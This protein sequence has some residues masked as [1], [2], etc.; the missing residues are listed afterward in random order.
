[1]WPADCR[2]WHGLPA[3]TTFSCVYNDKRL[4]W[5]LNI[6]SCDLCRV[7]QRLKYMYVSTRNRKDN[8]KTC[9][10]KSYENDDYF[11]S[12]NFNFLELFVVFCFKCCKMEFWRHE[13]I[14][15]LSIGTWLTD[16]LHLHIYRRKMEELQNAVTY[17][18]TRIVLVLVIKVSK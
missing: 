10:L 12:R 1:M 4:E 8:A 9:H 2:G 14:F 15:L 18:L 13:P 7:L 16:C 17:L 5:V 11:T 3:I 6:A